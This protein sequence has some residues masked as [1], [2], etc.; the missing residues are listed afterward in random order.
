MSN[1]T[2]PN[3]AP[4]P[5]AD[6]SGLTNASSDDH[7]VRLWLRSKS[8]NSVDAYAR[9]IH[10]FLSFEP[11]GLR[12]IK[13]EHI[14]SWMDQ[15]TSEGLATS[16]KARKLAAI[17]SL[18]SFAQKVGYL[19]VNV[20]AAVSLPKIP[21]LLAERILSESEVRRILDAAT[22]DRDAI[23]LRLFY[24]TGARVSELS[25]LK[26]KACKARNAD[27]RADGNGVVTLVGKG[28]KSR[29]VLIPPNVW[30]ELQQFRDAERRSGFGAPNDP[31][32]RSAKGGAL[33]RGGIW[34]VV[35]NSTRMSGV[36]RDVSPHWLRH[37]HASHSLD[38]GAPT[39]LVKE[40]LGHQSLA[41]T[42]R[43]THARPDDS[44]GNYLNLD[45]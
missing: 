25:T 37:A 6:S 16:T 36:E 45:D 22:T 19:E 14:W 4:T 10:Q 41:T 27:S 3:I 31:V 21:D 32:F 20:G 2:H 18:L 11:V 26:W 15:M 40:T 17:K 34:R 43:Y 9:D 5:A 29:N 13:I 8:P 7:L 35:K 28:S 12:A 38:R 24:V 1:L 44:S 23:L 30:S 42:S 33:S 39:H